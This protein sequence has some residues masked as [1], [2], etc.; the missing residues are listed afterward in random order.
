MPPIPTHTHTHTRGHIYTE[1]TVTTTLLLI[2]TNLDR[3]CNAATYNSLKKL[4]T[5]REIPTNKSFYITVHMMYSKNQENGQRHLVVV[6]LN[7]CR[8]FMAVCVATSS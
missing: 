8:C 5:L 6:L 2:S 7:C 1:T 3:Y 4:S